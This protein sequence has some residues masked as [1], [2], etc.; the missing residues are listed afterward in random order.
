MNTVHMGMRTNHVISA[1]RYASD[2]LLRLDK[3]S[4]W[5]IPMFR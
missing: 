3:D 1:S 4:V 2:K 5:Q